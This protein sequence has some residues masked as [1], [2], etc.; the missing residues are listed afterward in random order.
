MLDQNLGM[1]LLQDIDTWEN[2]CLALG[3]GHGWAYCQAQAYC[4]NTVIHYKPEQWVG[5]IIP[6][7]TRDL[8]LFKV[9]GWQLGCRYIPTHNM[10]A[11]DDYRCDIWF[12]SLKLVWLRTRLVVTLN[13]SNFQFRTE[14]DQVLHIAGFI[15]YLSSQWCAYLTNF[16]PNNTKPK[17]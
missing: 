13:L 5:V 4:G 9:A 8:H 17:V 10:V 2:K 7:L 3:K 1:A 14:P 16:P 15:G 6:N 11:G 12:V